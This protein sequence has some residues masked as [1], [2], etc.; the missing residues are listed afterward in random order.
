MPSII[1]PISA[2]LLS[3]AFLMVGHGIQV[4]V[5]P[6]RAEL[7]LFSSASIGAIT[8]FFFVGFVGGCLLGPHLIVRAGHIRAFAAMISLGSAA[9]LTHPL[10]ADTVTW[11]IARAITGFCIACNYLIIESWLNER[12]TNTT[13]GLVMSAYTIIVY[14]GIMVGQFSTSWLDAAGFESFVLSSIALSIAVIPVSLTKSAQ[15]APVA[16]VYFRPLK[17]YR[18]SPAAIVSV[19][20]DGVAVGALISLLPLYALRIGMD[21]PLIPFFAGALM[22]GGL[23]LQYPL[24]RFSDKVDRRY[25]LIVGA[26][27]AIAVSLFIAFSAIGNAFTLIFLVMLLG[28]LVQP[29]YAIAA[30]HAYDY[31][32]SGEM[33][34][35]AAGILLAYGIGSIL[36]P[37]AASLTMER[38]GP[39][40][41]FLVVA[42]ILA[43]MV[44]FLAIRLTQR[45]TLPDEDKNLYDLASAAPVGAVIAPDIYEGEDKYVLVPDEYDPGAVKA[46]ADQEADD[47]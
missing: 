15:P 28:S 33:V 19:I 32:E 11:S 42:A 6:I 3:V 12:S 10:F 9:A 35:T 26:A 7:E 24:G 14:G 43:A 38:Y 36:G 1:A 29:L 2:L 47:R 44:V 4:T 17:L 23:L 40:A 13:R 37:L 22:L 30:A 34:E 8:S 20:L 41:L 16:V 21:A 39:E 27:G 46:E 31:G 18:T 45:D 5:I 25:M